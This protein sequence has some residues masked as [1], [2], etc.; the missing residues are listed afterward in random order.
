MTIDSTA[1][2]AVRALVLTATEAAFGQRDVTAVD[3]YF[4]PNYTEH[5]QEAEDGTAGLRA[6][7]TSLP[8][9]FRYEQVRILVDGELVVTHGLYHGFDTV[10]L[11]AFDV[12]RVSGGKICEHWDALT[13]L[14]ER[15]ESG[16]GQIDGQ[17]HVTVP[18]ATASSRA[19][20]TRFA[21]DVL[22]GADHSRL[23]NYVSEQSFGHHNPDGADGLAGFESV[24][25][26]WAE[27][28]K[29]P[30]YHKIHQVIAEGE[31][32]FTRAEGVL[33]G[34]VV[35]NDL[36]RVADKMIVEH[37]GVV[38]PVKDEMAH[39]NGVF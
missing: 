39:N 3:R 4:A 21:E 26:R 7:I 20:V 30:A 37:W 1:E 36:W 23:A 29:N 35:F 6:F 12:W 17:R 34:P 22:V 18:N 24:F 28:G 19:V 10:P 31:F 16:H 5:G 32:V 2:D 14:V 11:V 38:E 33:D 13:R 15:S 9:D 25:A 27:A 8:D